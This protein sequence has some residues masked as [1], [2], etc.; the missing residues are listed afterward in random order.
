[1]TERMANLAEVEAG[2]SEALATWAVR[3]VDPSGFECILSIQAETGAEALKEGE[4][5]ITHLTDAKCSPSQK[6]TSNGN[7]RSNGKHTG[8]TLM[9]RPDGNAKNPICPIHG[10]EMTKWT[11]E[12]HTWYS[13]RFEDGWCKG[14]KA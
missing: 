11:R 10:I 2:Y 14:K 1:M 13:H 5:A 9:I 8:E 7:G 12:G 6:N 4:G 3:Y